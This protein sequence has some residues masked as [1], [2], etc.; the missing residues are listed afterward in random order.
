[1]AESGMWE[2]WVKIMGKSSVDKIF[3]NHPVSAATMQGKNFMKFIVWIS[4]ISLAIT[5]NVLYFRS[6]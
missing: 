2:R 1:M 3:E 4:G 6:I 5:I